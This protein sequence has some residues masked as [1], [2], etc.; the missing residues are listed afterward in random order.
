[1]I[2]ETRDSEND[3]E[4]LISLVESLLTRNVAQQSDILEALVKCEGDVNGAAAFLNQ[5]PESEPPK[6]KRE[7]KLDSWL[8]PPS[9]RARNKVREKPP[10]SS[11]SSSSTVPGSVPSGSKQP[12]DLSLLLRQPSPSKARKTVPKLP[13]LTLSTPALVAKHTPCTLHYSVL[14]QEL[15]CQLF[16]AML[17]LSK[18]W[19]RNKWWL[20]DRVVESPHRTSFFA[21]RTDGLDSDESWQDAAQFW[22]NGRRTVPPDTFPEPME[23]ACKIIEEIVNREISKRKRYPLEYGE[24]SSTPSVWRANVAASNC[25]EGSKESV[26]WHSDQVTYLGPYPTIASLS[27]GTTR[28]FSLRE[29]IPTQELDQ[30]NARTLNIPLPHNSLTIMHA[31]CQ[32]TFKH[33]IPPQNSIDKFRPPL[34]RPSKTETEPSISRINITFRFYR[35][36]FRPPSIP[37]CHCGIPTILRPD[38][39]GR[40]GDATYKYWW[41]C[42]AGAQN[43]GKGC[44]FWKVMDMSAEG[45]GPCIGG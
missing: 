1:M 27:L 10:V 29:V 20:F 16:Y 37:K 42:Y 31:S 39:K 4:T 33:S 19:K 6:R 18:E 41:T 5:K 43:D 14:P 7:N 34:P 21:R 15:A 17:D 12:V 30:R 38:M 23:K 11:G 32:E 44:N 13:P 36:D 9:K 26:G 3:T 40:V 25:Y 28:S 8:K 45:R 2:N 24:S 35:P 22:Y